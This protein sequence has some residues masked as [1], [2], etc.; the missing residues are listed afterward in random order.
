MYTLLWI[1]QN[2]HTVTTSLNVYNSAQTVNSVSQLGSVFT[3]TAMYLAKRYN[4]RR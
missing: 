4:L 3:V 1:F 2:S